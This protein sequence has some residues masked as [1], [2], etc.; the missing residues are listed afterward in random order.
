MQKENIFILD[1]V[2]QTFLALN[3]SDQIRFLRTR[4]SKTEIGRLGIHGIPWERF[5]AGTWIPAIADKTARIPQSELNFDI[6]EWATIFFI[7]V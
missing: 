4:L 6:C 2:C 5:G 3:S 1:L 7:P